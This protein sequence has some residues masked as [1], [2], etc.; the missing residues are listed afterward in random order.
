MTAIVFQ[1]C[2]N[3]VFFSPFF[4]TFLKAT[5]H[6][7]TLVSLHKTIIL[8]SLIYTFLST[9]SHRGKVIKLERTADLFGG[10]KETGPI[11][12]QYRMQMLFTL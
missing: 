3:K 7:R 9:G 12:F 4:L 5:G 6:E 11:H 10:H 8:V 1:A 2:I